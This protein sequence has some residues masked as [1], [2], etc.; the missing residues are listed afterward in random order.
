MSEILDA[1]EKLLREQG[2]SENPFVKDLRTYDREV[3]MKY[4]YPLEAKDMLEKIVFDIKACLLLGP[5]GVGKTSALYYIFYSLPRREFIPVFF[6]EPPKDISSIDLVLDSVLSS[7]FLNRFFSAFK[8]RN[9][10]VSRNELIERLKRVK[11]KVVFF[12]DEAHLSRED[13]FMEYKYLLDDVPNLRLVMAALGREPFPD[14]LIQLIGDSNIFQRKSFTE[15]EMT[16]IIE[17][18]ISAVGGRGIAPFTPRFLKSVFTDQNL[19]TPRYVFDEL[20]NY[21]ASVA[22]GKSSFDSYSVR[23][24]EQVVSE[25]REEERITRTNVDW[26]VLLSP[27]QRTV[28]ELLLKHPEGLTLPELMRE[29]G[30]NENTA[31]NALYQLRGEDSAE[32]KRKP[33]VPYPLVVVKQKFVGARKKNV[34]LMSPKIRNLFTL[35]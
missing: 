28:V 25:P 11:E 2:W 33:Q 32:R 8:N 10:I 24:E 17:H 4:Y 12:I 5:K 18:R 34:Y 27:S 7:G 15:E 29:T 9:R 21:L 20:N 1:K 14:S 13:M 19:L 6:K 30:F 23:E 35:H 31:F 3:F 22:L 16:K 26:F